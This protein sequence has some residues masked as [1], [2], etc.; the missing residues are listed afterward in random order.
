[1]KERQVLKS[2]KKILQ[3]KNPLSA[4]FLKWVYYSLHS[5]GKCYYGKMLDGHGPVITEIGFQDNE[6]NCVVFKN[7]YFTWKDELLKT[8][9][10]LKYKMCNQ[11]SSGQKMLLHKWYLFVVISRAV[12]LRDGHVFISW[13]DGEFTPKKSENKAFWVVHSCSG[14]VYPRSQHC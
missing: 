14:G 6:E 2:I 7:A 9:L 1:M 4:T 11:T 3:M 12:S 13:G 10:I 8:K 5:C